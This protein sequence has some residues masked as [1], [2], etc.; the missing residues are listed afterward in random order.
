MPADRRSGSRVGG[1]MSFPSFRPRLPWFG[2]DLQTLRDS[3]VPDTDGYPATH[4]RPLAFAMPDETGD[5]LL[6]Q[7]DEP[8]QPAG[9]RPLAVLIHGLTGCADSRYVRR[10]GA[11][12]LDA[13][14]P[15]LR[16]NLR[17]A[18]PCRPLCREQYHS[19]RSE[20]LEAVLRQLPRDLVA[21]GLVVIGW[22]LGAN[23]LLK[24]LAEFGAAHPIRAAVSVSA[25]IRL[26]EAATRLGSP[27]NTV[28]HRWLLARMR[29]EALRAPEALAA[30]LASRVARVRHI[31]EFDEVFT[32]PRNGYDDAADYY[33]RCSASAFMPAI[34]VPTLVI[35]ALDD[36][37]IPGAAYQAFD[38]PGSPNLTPLLPARGGHVG[39]HASGGRVWSDDCML[40]YLDRVLDGG[41]QPAL[42][43]WAASTAK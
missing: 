16:L 6:G 29:D 23:L 11:R 2:G 13:G 30:G 25:P 22:S 42:R 34:P 37:W 9:G 20:D 36:P 26:A 3:L 32:A 14:Y 15:V 31:I 8:C 17:G 7:L 35:H 39:F 38:W 10:A 33:A 43:R 41:T 4:S 27:R 40:A 19:G 21:E 12:L 24:G 1:A 18:G 5:R 28:Y